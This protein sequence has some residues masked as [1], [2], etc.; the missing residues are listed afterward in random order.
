MY[1]SENPQKHQL[2]IRLKDQSTSEQKLPTFVCMDPLTN[3]Q[4]SAVYEIDDIKSFYFLGGDLF[5][6]LIEHL[7]L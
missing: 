2:A 6:E 7:I 3:S 5:F 1:N 4:H